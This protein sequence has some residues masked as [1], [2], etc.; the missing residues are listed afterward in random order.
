MGS[1]LQQFITK[2]GLKQCSVQNSKV[3]EVGSGISTHEEER[4]KHI[5]MNLWDADSSQ[6][7]RE[8]EGEENDKN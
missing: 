4:R 2:E 8:N 3:A 7:E 6:N 5:P 1:L